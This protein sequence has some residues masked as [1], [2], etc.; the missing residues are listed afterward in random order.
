[1]YFAFFPRFS[2]AYPEL[3]FLEKVFRLGKKRL[4]QYRKDL[5]F[6]FCT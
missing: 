2:S 3:E 4:L 5:L 6:A 1:M